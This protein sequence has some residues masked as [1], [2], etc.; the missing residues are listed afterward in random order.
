[1]FNAQGHQSFSICPRN[2]ID[3]SVFHLCKSRTRSGLQDAGA[4]T[5]T[6]VH[7]PD[8]MQIALGMV[9]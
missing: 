1:M 4:A 2:G 3:Y 6:A 7:T 5:I 9:R 8:R